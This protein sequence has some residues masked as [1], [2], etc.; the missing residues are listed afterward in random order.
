MIWLW[1]YLGGIILLLVL[2]F[3]KEPVDEHEPLKRVLKRYL[4]EFLKLKEDWGFLLALILWP[5][6]FVVIVL[7]ILL[8][9]FIFILLPFCYSSKCFE[10][11]DE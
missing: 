11:I 7:F 3:L 10:Q 6:T 8:I 9:F 4:M 1:I 5:L 2:G